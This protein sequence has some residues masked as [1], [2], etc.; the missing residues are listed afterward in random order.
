MSTVIITRFYMTL[1]ETVWTYV[2]TVKSG[3][4]INTLV[5]TIRFYWCVHEHTNAI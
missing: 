2:Y 1:E 5:S 3:V 4:L